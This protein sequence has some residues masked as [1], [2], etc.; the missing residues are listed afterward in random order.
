MRAAVLEQAGEPLTIYDD[1]EIMQPRVGEVRVN[2]KYCGLCHSDLSIAN[3]TMPFGEHP[4][5]LANSAG[6]YANRSTPSE[7]VASRIIMSA[8]KIIGRPDLVLRRSLDGP[9]MR[10]FR[11]CAMSPR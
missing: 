3:G 7:A 5:I 8:T 6:L 4:I 9:T 11:L 10:W 1:V 2:V